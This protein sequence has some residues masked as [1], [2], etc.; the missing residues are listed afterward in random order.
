MS[1]TSLQSEDSNLTPTRYDGSWGLLKF[2][3]PWFELWTCKLT[4]L[5]FATVVER[6]ALLPQSNKVLGLTPITLLMWCMLVPMSVWVSL[7]QNKS[8]CSWIV[9]LICPQVWVW[10]WILCLHCDW[11]TACPGCVLCLRPLCA[12]DPYDTVKK[13]NGWIL[14]ATEKVLFECCCL[15]SLTPQ[16]HP[17]AK[18][19]L[20]SNKWMMNVDW[21]LCKTLHI[22]CMCNRVPLE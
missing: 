15:V 20:G 8:C 13:R 9:T 10:E 21:K 4:K 18:S 22:T 2:L 12:G 16:C 14:Q 5:Q 6:L 7:V 19:L 3:V 1:Y 17:A 11:L